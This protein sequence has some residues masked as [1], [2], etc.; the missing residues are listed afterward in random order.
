MINKKLIKEF[1][2]IQSEIFE[3]D[4]LYY[5]D[6]NSSKSDSAYDLL[7]KNYNK[8]LTDNKELRKYD[9]L[10]VGFKPS[11]KFSKV[12]HKVPMLS[13]TNAFDKKD[14]DEFE[15]KINK[16]L[17]NSVSFNFISDLKIDGVSLSLHYKDNKLIQ[18][19]TR[20]DGITGEDVTEN[21]LKIN[22]I[23]KELKDCKSKKI[24]IRGE[25]FINKKDFENL[26]KKIKE[27]NQ[28]ANPRNAASGS[29]RQLNPEITYARP[30]NF[31]PHGYGHIDN[32]DIFKTYEFFF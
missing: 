25:V 26:N 28:F 21:I 19:L 3:L 29:L 9:I 5:Q 17:N 7:K 18:A 13:L 2:E 6:S 30:L 10:T 12:R 31:I 8:L 16:F 27:S 15:D 14:L 20:G 22:G 32:K 1:K 24:E 11:E 23:P 4:K